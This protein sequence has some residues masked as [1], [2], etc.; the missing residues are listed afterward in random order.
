MSRSATTTYDRAVLERLGTR[1]LERAEKIRAK[2]GQISIPTLLDSSDEEKRFFTYWFPQKSQRQLFCLREAIRKESR[3]DL[4]NVAWA[5]FSS[6]IIAKSKSVSYAIDIPRS[7]PHKDGD[8][9]IDPPFDVWRQRFNQVVARL[10]FVDEQPPA[11]APSIGRGDARR[12]KKRTSSVDVVLTS[13]PYLNAVDYLR[14]HKFSLVWMGHDLSALR[15]RRGVMIGS[16]RGMWKPNGLPESIEQ[17]LKDQIAEE[18][19]RAMVRRY[20]SDLRYSM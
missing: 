2:I 8:R 4:R 6:L 1:V 10:P 12:L 7:R 17:T 20:L 15:K 13:P 16:E 19:E 18:R 9:E 14:G 3:S 11:C 5:V